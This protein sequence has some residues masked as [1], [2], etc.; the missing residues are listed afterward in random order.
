[1]K[2]ISYIEVCG[3][4]KFLYDYKIVIKIFCNIY[5]HKNNAI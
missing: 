2:I 1:M 5:F 3:K 4:N